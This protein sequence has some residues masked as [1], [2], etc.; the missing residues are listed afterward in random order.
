MAA[1][2]VRQGAPVRALRYIWPDVRPRL[3]S[4]GVRPLHHRWPARA[5]GLEAGLAH[6]G[7]QRD[8][9]AAG[10][11]RPRDGRQLRRVHR[12][13]RDRRELANLPDRDR[14]HLVALQRD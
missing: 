14:V 7:H 4:Q 13:R 11:D 5:G 9:R 2:S 6:R 3:K 10:R 12:Q 1:L 8:R